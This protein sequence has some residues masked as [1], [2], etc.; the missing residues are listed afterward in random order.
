MRLPA[1][2]VTVAGTRTIP[3]ALSVTGIVVSVAWAALRLTVTV[4]TA[5]SAS[6]AGAGR[7]LA[8]TGGVETTVTLACW[9]TPAGAAAIT[10]ASPG[11]IP[12]TAKRAEAVFAVIVTDAGAWTKSGV[13][14]L[15]MI[16]VSPPCGRTVT[17]HHPV[18]PAAI[19]PGQTSAWTAG[20]AVC[21]SRAA[22]TLLPLSAAVTNP[23]PG[24]TAV[25]VKSAAVAPAGMVS[26]DGKNGGPSAAL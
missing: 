19:A 8:R 11:A 25:T 7:T 18:A 10:D 24:K 3:G 13:V 9:L 17:V 1:G 23:A 22:P 2:T 20:G 21:T 15:S 16:S 14:V 12:V 6:V 4:V 5:P 26:T